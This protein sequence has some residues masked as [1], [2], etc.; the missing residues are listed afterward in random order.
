MNISV[1]PAEADDID[2]VA[3]IE[4][5]CFSQAWSRQ[6]FADVLYREDVLLL[7]AHIGDEE[8]AVG[9]VCMYMAVDEG[10][11]TNVAVKSDHRGLGIA[12]AL[13]D[14]L[15]RRGEEHGIEKIFLEVRESNKPAIGL[16]AKKGF[17]Q[18]GIRK[19]FYREPTE[20]A[21]VMIKDLRK[22]KV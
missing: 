20:N 9:Y 2:A 17:E 8:Q 19:A 12:D 16:Y 7:A 5:E 14:D 4:A 6:A 11:I 13:M 10:E 15:I 22:Q 1:K 3:A 18:C 21:L